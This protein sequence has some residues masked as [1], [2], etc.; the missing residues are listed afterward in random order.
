MAGGGLAQADRRMASL[1]GG[2]TQYERHSV[3]LRATAV[4]DGWAIGPEVA[5]WL[6][7]NLQPL[8]LVAHRSFS[9]ARPPRLGT[10]VS[11]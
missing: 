2:T 6:A 8:P 11:M 5:H 4:A 7:P 10:D 3:S 9:G 1:S